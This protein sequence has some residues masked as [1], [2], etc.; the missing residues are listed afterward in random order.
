VR[1]KPINLLFVFACALAYAGCGGRAEQNVDR[2][3]PSMTSP[4]PPGV[5]IIP[6]DSP[7]LAQIRVES[8]KVEAMPAGEVTAPGKG[9]ANPNRISRVPLPVAGRVTQ[10]LVK[11]GDGV[12]AGPPLPPAERPQAD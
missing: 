1:T 2:L 9:E 11:L 7:K 10:V 6:P 3:A 8:I 4:A 12:A 5:V